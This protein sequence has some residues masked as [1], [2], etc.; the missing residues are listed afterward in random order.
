MGWSPK[1]DPQPL[2]RSHLVWDGVTCVRVCTYVHG[3]VHVYVRKNEIERTETGNRSNFE[4]KFETP[5]RQS[6]EDTG[7]GTYL[8]KRE[9]DPVAENL[10][11]DSTTHFLW[12]RFVIYVKGNRFS[13]SPSFTVWSLMKLYN[14]TMCT[15]SLITVI[16]T[17]FQLWRF[18][19]P[20]HQRL[21]PGTFT[22]LPSLVDYTPVVFP[23]DSSKLRTGTPITLIPVKGDGLRVKGKF[24]SP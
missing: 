8:V 1:S 18:I 16:D 22:P 13:T 23:K 21:F 11:S 9:C 19:V 24:D 5:T 7:I 17:M 3:W 6:W 10:I 14:R 15:H 20:Y 2:F 12:W 4:I